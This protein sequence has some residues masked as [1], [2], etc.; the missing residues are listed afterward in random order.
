MSACLIIKAAGQFQC[1]QHAV[2]CP[3]LL[4]LLTKMTVVATHLNL[5]QQQGFG[6]NVSMSVGNMSAAWS[7][8]LRVTE[9]ITDAQARW[10]PCWQLCRLRSVPLV[11]VLRP[12]SSLGCIHNSLHDVDMVSGGLVLW[13]GHTY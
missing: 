1:D 4:C 13:R 12:R 10:R 6:E 2:R 3:A 11:V 8:T 5:A 9:S 7:S